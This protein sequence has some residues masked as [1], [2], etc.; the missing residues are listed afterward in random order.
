V[1]SLVAVLGQLDRIP[2]QWHRY[3]SRVVTRGDCTDNL[4]QVVS[5]TATRLYFEP[6]AVESLITH[7]DRILCRRRS[8]VCLLLMT[9]T[10]EYALFFM[11]VSYGQSHGI[12]EHGIDAIIAACQREWSRFVSLE[13]FCGALKRKDIV[14]RR[15]GGMELQ[16]VIL[17]K[18]AAIGTTSKLQ[19]T[20]LRK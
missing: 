5:G 3:D 1:P 20:W 13:E 17:A 12:S 16:N 9:L 19:V 8:A 14:L 7:R 10:F 11:N 18:A 6:S 15:R 2:S 4:W